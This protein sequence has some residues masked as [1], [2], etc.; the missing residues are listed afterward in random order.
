MG[1]YKIQPSGATTHAA[2]KGIIKYVLNPEKTPSYAYG[3]TGHFDKKITAGNVYDSFLENKKF[4]NQDKGRMYRHIELCFP[5]S[6]NISPQEARDFAVEFCEKAFSGH[7][8]VI[9]VHENTDDIHA[10]CV[11]DYVNYL[12]GKRLKCCREDLYRHRAINDQMC[13]ERGLYVPQKGFHYDGTPIGPNDTIAWSRNKYHAIKYGRRKSDIE[14]LADDIINALLYSHSLFELLKRLHDSLWKL[15]WKPDMP[16]MTFES[17]ET[18]RKFRSTNLEK[19]YGEKFRSVFGEEFILDKTHMR[20]LFSTPEKLRRGYF[21]KSEEI[22]IGIEND[23]KYQ[24]IPPWTP[25]LK[26]KS[27]S[28]K[29]KCLHIEQ[30]KGSG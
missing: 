3:I 16:Y 4:W 5:P 30:E 27:I 28:P 2:L 23:P 18:G 20:I 10:H 6:D 22:H 29:S 9:S 21:C 19:H 12:D 11:I 1:I 14:R 13:R 15:F 7:M 17:E 24:D 8:A 26:T 25:P